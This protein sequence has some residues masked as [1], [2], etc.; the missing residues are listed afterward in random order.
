MALAR[1]QPNRFA[2][3]PASKGKDAPP[4]DLAATNL[5]AFE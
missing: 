3:T 4:M 2:G 1:V 5:D